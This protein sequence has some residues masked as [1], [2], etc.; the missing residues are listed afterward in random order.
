L[1]VSYADALGCS[2]VAGCV[3]LGVGV[4]CTLGLPPPL[5]LQAE[6]ASVQATARTLSLNEVDMIGLL[7]IRLINYLIIINGKKNKKY[8]QIELH[9]KSWT[10]YRL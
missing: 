9:P 5:E 7:E 10:P 3:G 6:R 2:G 4:G 8:H 1:A